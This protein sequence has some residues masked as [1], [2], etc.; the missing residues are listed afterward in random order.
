MANKYGSVMGY[1]TH[2][3]DGPREPDARLHGKPYI[4]I[5]E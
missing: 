5:A 1:R 3:V 2:K 4:E